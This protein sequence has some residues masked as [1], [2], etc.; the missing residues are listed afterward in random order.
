M[1][2]GYAHSS[3]WLL[4]EDGNRQGLADCN[5]RYIFKSNYRYS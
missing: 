4:L 5:L 3:I 1:R 2:S